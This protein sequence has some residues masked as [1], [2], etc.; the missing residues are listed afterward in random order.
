MKLLVVAAVLLVGAV[1]ADECG[2]LARLKVKHQWYEA[3]G[4]GHDRI[5]LG[6]KLW[7]K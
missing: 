4:H 2:A 7:N 1:S 6:L 5:I 3:Y